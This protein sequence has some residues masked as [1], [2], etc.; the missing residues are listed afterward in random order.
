LTVAVRA[1]RCSLPF[2]TMPHVLS[3]TCNAA[4]AWRCTGEAV[5][6]SR[7]HCR[8]H[9]VCLRA[10]QARLCRRCDRLLTRVHLRASDK[11][12]LCHQDHCHLCGRKWQG[13]DA[14]TS[15]HHM[16][17]G[18]AFNHDRCACKSGAL[19]TCPQHS[20]MMCVFIL[21]TDFGP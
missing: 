12:I 7:C 5:P 14:L 4:A 3:V 11:I 15:R 13:G 21:C 16:C 8:Q 17:S 18:H 9:A 20:H 19:H 1:S 2:C 10:W 6:V